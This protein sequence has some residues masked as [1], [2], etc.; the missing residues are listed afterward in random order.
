MAKARQIA[1]NGN[2]I[3]P[4]KWFAEAL[5]LRFA[6]VL[7]N[8]EAALD[9][10]SSK[11]IHDMRVAIRRFRSVIRDFAEIV[12]GYPLKK[13][14]AD[15]KRLADSLG[16][17]RDADVAAE[18]LDKLAARARDSSVRDGIKLIST[19]FHERRCR[20]FDRLRSRLSDDA[21][22]ALKERFDRTIRGSLGQRNLFDT[23]DLDSAFRKI[24]DNRVADFL[25]LSD[26]FYDPF[27][28]RRLHRL[29]IAGK[30]LRYAVELFEAK[31]DG[32]PSAMTGS[33]AKMQT[34]L[35]DCHDCDMW[36]ARLRTIL[37][38]KRRNAVWDCEREATLWLLS[39]F[40]R[41][42][43]KAY[44]SALALWGD[45]EKT[46]F[47]NRLKDWTAAGAVEENKEPGT[48]SLSN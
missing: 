27:R 46:R 44:R 38:A 23:T 13:I 40:I 42:R 32:E 37:K 28:V 36:I 45:W 35:G 3:D 22:T 21:I 11:G 10:Q 6:E 12:E 26:A 39:Q 20:G 7:A 4:Q 31:S 33:I 8:R 15:L 34:Y 29:R 41:L 16:E 48:E 43:G 24:I 25:E 19:R 30:H 5:Q 14:R 47:L 18:A 17:V 9:P 2:A 1:S